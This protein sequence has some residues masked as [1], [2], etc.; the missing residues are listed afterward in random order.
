MPISW[1]TVSESLPAGNPDSIF[2]SLVIAIFIGAVATIISYR[3]GK[4][5]GKGITAL[6][7]NE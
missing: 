7:G 1:L 6:S 5:K 3:R 2:I 4:W